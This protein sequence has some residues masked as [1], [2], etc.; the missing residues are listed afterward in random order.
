MDAVDVSLK[1]DAIQHLI[2]V[3]AYELWENEGR[4]QG[5]DLI[6]W[7]QAKQEIMSCVA[8]AA[9]AVGPPGDKTDP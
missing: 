8:G 7:H 5:Y 3:R 6:N 1:S 9:G 4:P 2:A